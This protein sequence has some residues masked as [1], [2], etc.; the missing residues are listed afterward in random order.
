MIKKRIHPL[1][2]RLDKVLLHKFWGFFL[3]LGILF[4]MFQAIYA[5]A[6]YPMDAIDWLFG[7]WQETTKMYLPKGVL[8]DLL[9]DGVI[10]GLGGIVIFIP[11]IAILFGLIT[12]L[13]ESGYMARV[14]FMM[15]KLMRKFG[16]NGKSIVPLISGVA[17]A[18]PAVMA[19][20]NIDNWKE[21]LITI[22]VT[23]LMSCSA[24]LPVYTILIA[25][26][27]PDY[28][29]LGFINLQG[30]M[31]M[32][33]YLLGFVMALIS[34]WV[35]KKILKTPEK[36][37]LIMEFPTYKFPRWANI[38]YVVVEKVKV[39]VWEAGKIILAISIILWVLSSYGPGNA[40]QQAEKQAI[41]RFETK[42][43]KHPITLENQIASARLEASYIG[44]FGKFIEPALV[45]LGYDWKIG[46]ALITSFAAREVFVGTISTIYSMG[47]QGDDL[48]TL[49]SRM[50]AEI[51]PQT[52]EKRYTF[53]VGLSLL[54]FYAFALQCMSTIAIVYR[55]TKSRKWTLIQFLYFTT[56]AYLS[57]FLV[58][59]LFS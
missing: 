41:Q 26:I 9:A 24:R 52:G 32:G 30:L 10:A 38:G 21:R 28:F 59:Q 51:N 22:F 31:L 1:L 57:S 42:T 2:A 3:F 35:M 58:Y 12:I 18:I 45:P 13:E 46:I 16:L 43:H 34:A 54:M 48:N 36:S 23:P 40:M 39:F 29:I 17:C 15:D 33:M 37:F 49:K 20:R 44:Q 53:A 56:L 5:W 47:N 4:L 25:L 6:T 11:Q 55:E 19:T 27:I 14:I 50:L 7:Y 8:T